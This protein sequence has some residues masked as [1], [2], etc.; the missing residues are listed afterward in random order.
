MKKLLLILFCFPIIGFG[1]KT[2]PFGLETVGKYPFKI[3]LFDGEFGDRVYK[4]V[5]C[6]YEI[7]KKCI[8][9]TPVK[10]SY[11]S[12]YV[13]VHGCMEH[14]YPSTSYDIILDTDSNILYIKVRDEFQD[15]YFS[16]TTGFPFKALKPFIK[17]E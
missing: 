16:E 11:N 2:Q 15:T 4:L 10:K 17:L 9:E 7:I 12:R 3:N 6:K 1:Q 5:G 13:Y 14:S 8:V